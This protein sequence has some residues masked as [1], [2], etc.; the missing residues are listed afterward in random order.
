LEYDGED[1]VLKKNKTRALGGKGK[2]SKSSS[3]GG[4]LI[5]AELKRQ[6]LCLATGGTQATEKC[7]VGIEAF[8]NFCAPGIGACGCSNN[9]SEDVRVCD[10]PSDFCFD[11]DFGCVDT[12]NREMCLDSDGELD[13]RSTCIAD[14][15]FPTSCLA[16]DSSGGPF[17]C[18]PSSI[19]TVV[20]DCGNISCFVKDVGCVDNEEAGFC[21]ATDGIVE[22]AFA[23][24]SATDFDSTCMP[25]DSVGGGP[26]G[27][28]P[29]SQT[30]EIAYCECSVNSDHCY[31]NGVGCVSDKR[32]GKC[33]KDDG[34]IV[35]K[36]CCEDTGDFADICPGASINFEGVCDCNSGDS[37]DTVICK[38]DVDRC[39]NGKKCQRLNNL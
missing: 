30:E 6:A 3:G 11:E 2:S 24:P 23:C 1:K 25:K 33:L 38:C 20:C 26:F 32:A 21:L 28:S 13:E 18:G 22:K 34:Q 14:E 7:C 8:A 12:S 4:G 9:N 29:S 17:D 36:Q 15:Q 31:V 37:E 39:W 35:I 19:K 16:T 27:C 5:A 10:C